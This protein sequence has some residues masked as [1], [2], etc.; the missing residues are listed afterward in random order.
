MGIRGGQEQHPRCQP[1][2]PAASHALRGGCF[3]VC[4]RAYERVAAPGGPGE[5]EHPCLQGD[6]DPWTA[7]AS[8]SS[9]PTGWGFLFAKDRC[10]LVPSSA[11]VHLA[12]PGCLCQPRVEPA[13]WVP[14]GFPQG[15]GDQPESRSWMLCEAAI[16]FW[17]SSWV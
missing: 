9:S 14:I 2:M 6:D 11:A 7:Q 5:A 13:G 12:G 16:A 4:R 8:Q 15:R 3:R 17:E 1:S 10:F